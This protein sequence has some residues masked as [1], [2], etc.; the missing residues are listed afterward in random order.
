M[1]A[2]AEAAR[3]AL[4]AYVDCINRGDAQGATALFAP[5]AVIEDPVGTP[6]KTGAAIARWF[7]DTVAFGTR[8]EPVAPIRGSHGAAAAIALKVRF[9]PPDGQRL[10]ICSIDI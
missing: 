4:Q 5:D 7:A 9:T 10:R 6:P 1:N 8:I 2:G 3:T